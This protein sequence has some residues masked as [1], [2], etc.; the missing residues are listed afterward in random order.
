MS[1]C[2]AV[3]IGMACSS[4]ASPLAVSVSR[5]ER[6]SSASGVTFSKPRHSNGLRLA[7]SMV[8]SI[9]SKLATGDDGDWMIQI[10]DP[11]GAKVML[12]GKREE[13]AA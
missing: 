2:A 12:T 6:R 1:P 8:R 7:V 9:A 11:H 3:Q 4:S 13:G 5:R 10:T